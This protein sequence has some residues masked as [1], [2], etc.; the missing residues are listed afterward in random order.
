MAEKPPGKITVPKK[1]CP[2]A[3]GPRLGFRNLIH[4]HQSIHIHHTSIHCYE[5][6]MIK[7]DMPDD[8]SLTLHWDHVGAMFCFRTLWFLHSWILERSRCKKSYLRDACNMSKR[9]AGPLPIPSLRKRPITRWKIPGKISLPSTWAAIPIPLPLNL[10][11]MYLHLPLW[12]NMIIRTLHVVH[13]R[14]VAQTSNACVSYAVLC[15][16]PAKSS[17]DDLLDETWWN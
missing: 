5:K 7:H 3:N 2:L 13:P 8:A 12:H 10:I 1:R 6:N 9:A 11:A 17:N 15:G 4:L 16:P 14:R